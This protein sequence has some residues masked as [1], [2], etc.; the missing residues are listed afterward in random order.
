MTRIRL[1]RADEQARLF[2]IWHD[3]V[4]ATHGFLAEEDFAFYARLVRDEML[5]EGSVWV[6]V[7]EGDRPLAWLELADGKVEALF[8]DPA[9]F[10]RGLGRA[11]MDHAARLSPDGLSLDANEES[12]AVAFY[13]RLGFAVT[14]RSETDGAGRPYP[15]V[16]MRAR[17]AR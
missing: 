1:A 10:R 2:D 12:G 5:P 6:A 16:H 7:D 11:L 17:G 15:L 13:S 9:H 8:V 4:R 3:A 14:G